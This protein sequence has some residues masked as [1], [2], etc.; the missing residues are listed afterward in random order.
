MVS[1]VTAAISASGAVA[2][3]AEDRRQVEFGIVFDHAE[4]VA[5][6]A[7]CAIGRSCNL[8]G[9]GDSSNFLTLLMKREGDSIVKEL[10][11]TC[12]QECSFSN[13]RSSVT[14]DSERRFD[15][16]AGRDGITIPLVLKPRTRIGQILFV[17]H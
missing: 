7:T 17:V 11:V 14:F 4:P 2:G 8:L 1:F 13:G 5:G 12:E 3:P 15:L 10:S 9:G 6:H 16:F